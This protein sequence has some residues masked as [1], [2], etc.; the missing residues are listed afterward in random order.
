MQRPRSFLLVSFAALLLAYL[1]VVIGAY[2]RLS[3]AG[4]GCPDWPGCYGRAVAPTEAEDIARANAAFPE[5]PVD[6]SRAVKEMIHRYA[7][8]SLGILIVILSLLAWRHRRVSGQPVRIPLLLLALV[9]AQALLGMWTVTWLLK[10][11]VVTAHLAGGLT[12][13]ALL[14]WLVLAQFFH[15]PS[16]PGTQAD[17][18]PWA[19][20]ALCVLAVQ[21]F[22]G[23]WASA[24]YAALVCP[25]FPACRDGSWWPPVDFREAFVF[26]RGLGTNYEGGVLDADARTAIHISHRIG[27]L[28]SA[29]VIGAV[30]IRAL[31]RPHRRAR[32]IGMIIGFLLCV[33]IGLGI[34]NVLMR[35]PLPLAVAHNGMAALLLLSLVALLHHA[36]IT[37]NQ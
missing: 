16:A 22:L 5:R 4:L 37:R 19:L 27:A 24:N 21:I 9:I 3:H 18:L 10:P 31:L 13:L 33:Q 30:A 34:A 8:G 35:L 29:V 1:V 6:E 17:L 11:I 23:G 28:A 15:G 20:G 25:E 26:W 12:I 32:L 7:A 36:L 14:F 2:T